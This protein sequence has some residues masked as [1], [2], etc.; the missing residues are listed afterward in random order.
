MTVGCIDVIYGLLNDISAGE[1]SGQSDQLR[2]RIWPNPGGDEE[3]FDIQP[4]GR[5]KAAEVDACK[6]TQAV[7]LLQF[8]RLI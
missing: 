6:F 2:L 7:C 8:L 3:I 4:V 1:G 5:I